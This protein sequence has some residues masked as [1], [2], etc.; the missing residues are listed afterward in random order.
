M[1]NAIKIQDNS[2]ATDIQRPLTCCQ[3]IPV[4]SCKSPSEAIFIQASQAGQYAF[5][6]LV[7]T[8]ILES[9]T[10]LTVKTDI[11]VITD[12]TAHLVLVFRSITFRSFIITYQN[13]FSGFG[14][15]PMRIVSRSEI[16]SIPACGLSRHSGHVNSVL[17]VPFRCLSGRKIF[18][19]K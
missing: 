11:F 6:L 1:H 2:H 17:I 8:L 16:Q 9:R 7:N 15:E 19:G 12:K 10:R 4:P 18:S 3:N 5:A 13:R 14:Q